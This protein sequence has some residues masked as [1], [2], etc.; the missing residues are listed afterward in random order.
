MFFKFLF[1]SD[2]DILFNFSFG[3]I[4]RKLFLIILINNNNTDSDEVHEDKHHHNS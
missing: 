1:P 3:S 4:N 2:I